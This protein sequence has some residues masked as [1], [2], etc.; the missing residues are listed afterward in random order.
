MYS[1]ERLQNFQNEDEAL[2]VSWSCAR[3]KDKVNKSYANQYF[4]YQ[5]AMVP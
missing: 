2:D 1:G 5:N 3:L 4:V